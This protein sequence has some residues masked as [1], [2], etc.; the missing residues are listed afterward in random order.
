M[1][2]ST[3]DVQAEL[4]EYLNLKNINS[5]FIQIVERLLIEKPE[6]PIG[7]IVEYLVKTYPDQTRAAASGL[8]IDPQRTS[9]FASSTASRVE[10]EEELDS[11]LDDDDDFIDEAEF[12]YISSNKPVGRRV[13]VSAEQVGP[14]AK[15]PQLKKVP[16]SD[17]ESARILDI[18]HNNMIFKHLDEQQINQVKDSMFLVEK[19]AGNVVIKAGDTGDNFYVIDQGTIDVYVQNKDTESKAKSMGPGEAFGELALMYSTP[20]TATCKA[21]T[22]LRLWALDRISFKVILQ[23]TTTAKRKQAKVFLDKVPILSSLTEYEVLTIADALVEESYDDGDIV[24]K[25]GEQGDAFYIIKQGTVAILQTDATGEDTEVT[26][27][28]EGHYFGEVA[29]M[30]G[31]VRQATVKAVATLKLLSLDRKTFKRVMGP[32]EDILKRNMNTYKNIAARNI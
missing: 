8:S 31:T 29:L 11:D 16:K 23:A 22:P 15:P 12:Q 9:H 32:M 20:R 5:L 3:A 4:K 2:P 6:N 24:C 30:V 7:F 13:S 10:S 26:R 19:E 21:A 1:D 28:D 25:Q 18:L 17:D 27:L 14:N